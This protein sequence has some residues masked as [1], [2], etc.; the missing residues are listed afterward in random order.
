VLE[1]IAAETGAAYI[2]DLRDDD[3]PGENGD[4]EHSY[5]GLMAFDFR[6]FMGALGG[7]PSAFDGFDVSNLQPGDTVEYAS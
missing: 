2:D 5:L 7:D 3:L 6:T 4:P 1:Q